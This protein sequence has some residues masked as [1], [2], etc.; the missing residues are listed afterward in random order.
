MLVAA[1]LSPTDPVLAAAIVGRRAVPSRVR[2]LLNVESGLND[3]LALPVVVVL[4][5]VAARRPVDLASLGLALVGGVGSGSRCRCSQ[6]DSSGPCQ[7]RSA[8]G[9]KR[10]PRWRSA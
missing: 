1:V 7:S 10:W 9:T 3:G 2:H 5:D 6:Q 8:S 4:I